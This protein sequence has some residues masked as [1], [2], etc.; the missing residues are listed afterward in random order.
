MLMDQYRAL[1]SVVRNNRYFA[2][3]SVSRHDSREVVAHSFLTTDP[4]R[5]RV[6][7][8]SHPARCLHAF[9]LP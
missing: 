4:R 5:P 7:L 6:T 9:V 3:F 1:A 8:V 2:T